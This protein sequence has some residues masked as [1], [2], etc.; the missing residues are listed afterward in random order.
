MQRFIIATVGKTHSGKTTF[1]RALERQ[2][3][4]SVTIDQDVHAEFLLNHYPALIPTGGSHPLKYAITK[5][6]VDYAVS[7]TNHHIILSNSNENRVNRLKLLNQ[8]HD[9][10]FMSILINFDI[11]KDVLL[12]RIEKSGRR[13]DILRTL[14]SFNEVLQ[15]QETLSDQG[16]N[17]SPDDGEADYLFTIT[18][19]YEVEAVI[20][21][22]IDIVEATNDDPT[23]SR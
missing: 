20:R 14:S 21:K 4:N 3:P 5:T 8:F 22:I 2:L 16:Y 1:A 9:Q 19:G 10:G 11:P 7:E 23:H 17:T 18:S 12:E 13:T 15:T 6:V